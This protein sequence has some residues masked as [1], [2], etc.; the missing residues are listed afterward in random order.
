MKFF[1]LC[2]NLINFCNLRKCCNSIIMLNKKG[3]ISLLFINKPLKL[4]IYQKSLSITVFSN[5]TSIYKKHLLVTFKQVLLNKLFTFLAIRKEQ[6]VIK[7]LGFRCTFVTVKNRIF[8][9]FKLNYSHRITVPIHFEIFSVCFKKDNVV[10]LESRNIKQL[11]LLLGLFFRLK[12]KNI[13]RENGVFFRRSVSFISKP[14][15]KK[16]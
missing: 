4:F 15:K 8:L 13:Y 6:I 16:A 5:N 14:G 12:P 2:F 3:G 1:S 10:L 7:G 11:S 9:V